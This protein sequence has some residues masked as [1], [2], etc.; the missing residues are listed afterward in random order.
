[1]FL[2]MQTKLINC[3]FTSES[4][5]LTLWNQFKISAKFRQAAP[6][7]AAFAADL[8]VWKTLVCTAVEPCEQ[9]Q[10]LACRTASTKSVEQQ[11]NCYQ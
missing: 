2:K 1:M 5:V 3:V 11:P 8:K 6:E 4:E 9:I 7:S 10:P